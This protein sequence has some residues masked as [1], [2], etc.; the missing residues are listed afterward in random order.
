MAGHFDGIAALLDYP[1]YV[2]TACSGGDRSG[3]LVGFGTQCSME[4]VRWLA[5][6][7]KVNHTWSVAMG[8]SV[9]VVHVLGSDQ[10]E[11]ASLFG[12]ETGDEVDKFASCAWRPGPDGATPVL[13]DCAAWFAGR[14]L[15]KVDLGDH[16]GFVLEPVRASEPPEGWRPLSFQAVKNL[17]PGHPV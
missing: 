6:I 8:A 3:C 9:L 10:H 2:V 1:M 12:E 14:V 16:T 7:S 11:L 15:D 13:D 4:P 5:C 17:E